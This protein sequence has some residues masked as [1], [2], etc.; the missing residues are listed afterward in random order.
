M[1]GIRTQIWLLAG[2]GTAA[3]VAWISLGAPSP[4]GPGASP[5]PHPAGERTAARP[6]PQAGAA[7]RRQTASPA[8]TAPVAPSV[9]GRPTGSERHAAD[10][11]S[12]AGV[13][14]DIASGG[15]TVPT[16]L[17]RE[18]TREQIEI[19]ERAR[20]RARELGFEPP[21]DVSDAIRSQ[22][23][24]PGEDEPAFADRLRDLEVEALNDELLVELVLQ[25]KYGSELYRWGDP[26]SFHRAQAMQRVRA[27]STEMRAARLEWA[28]K[29]VDGPARP[30]F[31]PPDVVAPYE[32]PGAEPP[33]EGFRWAE[34]ELYQSSLLSGP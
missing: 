8:Q 24:L 27:M 18:K 5:S 28:L 13:G 14:E 31:Y 32:G 21:P 15:G 1:L 3:L 30:R 16:L 11:G 22:E 26:T 17:P 29:R 7:E 10:E 33:P 6:P 20:D 9:G 25:F 23:P 4:G 12:T 2:L 19:E 34:P